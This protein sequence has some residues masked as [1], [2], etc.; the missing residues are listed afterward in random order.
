MVFPELIECS[1]RDW[2]RSCGIFTC[3]GEHGSVNSSRVLV[4]A[5]DRRRGG[6]L[7]ASWSWSIGTDAGGSV[8]CLD[9]RLDEAGEP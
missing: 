7:T 2:I 4:G 1:F 3:S 9:E 6:E 5:V 8:S